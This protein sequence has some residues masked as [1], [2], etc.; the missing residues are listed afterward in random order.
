MAAAVAFFDY[1]LSFLDLIQV[2]TGAW[3]R[4]FRDLHQVFYRCFLKLDAVSTTQPSIRQNIV[5][6]IVY[7]SLSDLLC[8]HTHSV[9]F[10]KPNVSSRSS[11][12]PSGSHKPQ[13]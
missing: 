4:T 11:V 1:S 8:H 2:R 7:M 10:L 13:I 9:V 5:S 3:V 6:R 12:T